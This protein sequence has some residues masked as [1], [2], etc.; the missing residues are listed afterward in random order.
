[1]LYRVAGRNPKNSNQFR[2]ETPTITTQRMGQQ[3]RAV[4]SR[5][6]TANAALLPQTA[7]Q[8]KDLGIDSICIKDMAGI[9]APTV[10]FE[11]VKRLKDELKLPVQL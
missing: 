6:H 11:L 2:Q 10:A 3:R 5:K 1:M 4:A 8:Q 9:I 7:R